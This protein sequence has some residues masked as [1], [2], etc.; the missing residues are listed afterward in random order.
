VNDEDI[1]QIF[2]LTAVG[3][4]AL[5][6]LGG[7]YFDRYLVPLVPL[8]LYLNADRLPHEGFGATIRKSAAA[9]L[10]IFTAVFAVL[11]TRDYLTW[12][13]VLWEALTEL[14]Q[15]AG[16]SAHD[17]DGGFDYNGWFFEGPVDR[18]TFD[19]MIFRNENAKY[20]M[21]SS[22]EPGFKILKDYEYVT[23][24]PPGVRTLFLLEREAKS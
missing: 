8:L 21:S 6:M 12:H 7:G 4:Y 2:F 15:T 11:G 13:R 10:I 3:A 16:V 19:K 24:M 18:E 9:G 5:P 23:W 1:I 17:I 14:Q 22:K 20:R